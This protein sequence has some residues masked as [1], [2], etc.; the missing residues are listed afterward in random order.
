MA[1]WEW[2]G[3]Q[4]AEYLDTQDAEYLGEEEEEPPPGGGNAQLSTK[5][6]S[7]VRFAGPGGGTGKRVW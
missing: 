3:W 2:I 4:D 1:D 6:F 7:G 5:R